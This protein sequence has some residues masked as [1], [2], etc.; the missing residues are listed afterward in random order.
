MAQLSLSVMLL[1]KVY[2][3]MKSEIIRLP[4]NYFL[5]KERL[6]NTKSEHSG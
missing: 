1:C 3:L 6:D 2:C 4:L 5:Q